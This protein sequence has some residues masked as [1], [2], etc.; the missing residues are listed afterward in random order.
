LATGSCSFASKAPSWAL[1]PE[2]MSFVASVGFLVEWERMEISLWL[3]ALLRSRSKRLQGLWYLDRHPR[4]YRRLYRSAVRTTGECCK[5]PYTKQTWIISVSLFK[6]NE[7]TTEITR[8]EDQHTWN[9]PEQEFHA[10]VGP[11]LA[12]I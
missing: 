4:E 5:Q 8:W 2:F 12:A 9:P 3:L 11:F 10:Q 1:Q 7:E 6:V